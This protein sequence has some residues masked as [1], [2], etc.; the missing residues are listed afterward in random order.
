MILLFL[1]LGQENAATALL[2]FWLWLFSHAVWSFCY[3]NN[4]ETV[5]ALG[6]ECALVLQK[7]QHLKDFDTYAFLIRL[8]YFS[9]GLSSWTPIRRPLSYC[10]GFGWGEVN[11]DQLQQKGL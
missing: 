8:R 6:Q 3:G 11:P 7:T 5:A 1:L 9:A 2:L 4:G 10:V